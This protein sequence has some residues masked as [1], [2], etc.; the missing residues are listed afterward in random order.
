MMLSEF[1]ERIKWGAEQYPNL[2]LYVSSY[3]LKPEFVF[4]KEPRLLCAHV[5][6]LNENHYLITDMP[7]PEGKT[8]KV[9][10]TLNSLL[11]SI[12]AFL[13][14]FGDGEIR[15]YSS[16]YDKQYFNEKSNDYRD[17][18]IDLD[19]GSIYAATIGTTIY[20]RNIKVDIAVLA[21]YRRDEIEEFLKTRTTNFNVEFI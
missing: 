10:H 4:L 5:E 13:K 12:D 3:A 9:V 21:D 7:L 16:N 6:E 1:R 18:S 19:T 11:D 20:T 8:I 2:P 15:T 17:S 14:E